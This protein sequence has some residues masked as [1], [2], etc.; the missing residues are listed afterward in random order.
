MLSGIL[1]CSAGA[2]SEETN[3]EEISILETMIVTDSGQKSKLSDTNASIHVITA[4]DIMNS[5][6]KSTVEAITSIP[7]VINQK[8]GSKNI[9]QRPGHTKQHEQRPQNLC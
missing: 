7:G 4:K 8:F 6:Q 1:C 5:G 9:Y 3:T 2:A